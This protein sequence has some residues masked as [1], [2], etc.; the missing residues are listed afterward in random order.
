MGIYFV[1]MIMSSERATSYKVVIIVLS[2]AVVVLL[3]SS[4]EQNRRIEE[5]D[6]EFSYTVFE[7]DDRNSRQK[8]L[9]YS[10]ND[11][12]KDVTSV[13]DDELGGEQ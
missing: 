8:Q 3:K 1:I 2:M 12:N 7:K 5:V 13:E 9:Q 10:Q 4:W 6:G 11:M